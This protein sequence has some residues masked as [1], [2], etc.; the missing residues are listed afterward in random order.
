MKSRI[1]AGS[2]IFHCGMAIIT[3]ASALCPELV[4]A[5]SP[6]TTGATAAQASLLTILT[7]VAAVAV[8]ASGAMAWFGRVSWWWFI[9]VVMGVVMVFGSQQIVSWIRGLAGV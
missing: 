1:H 3:M 4:L 6:F 8:M 2:R 9:G 7:P 5:G